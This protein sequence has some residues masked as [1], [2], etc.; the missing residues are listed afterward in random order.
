[1]PVHCFAVLVEETGAWIILKIDRCIYDTLRLFLQFHLIYSLDEIS[2][3][4]VTRFEVPIFS[5]LFAILLT[6][7]DYIID[8]CFRSRYLGISLNFNLDLNLFAVNYWHFIV[9]RRLFSKQ[10]MLIFK[11]ILIYH[12]LILHLHLHFIF[13]ILHF[14]FFHFLILLLLFLS[15]FIRHLFNNFLLIFFVLLLIDFLVSNVFLIFLR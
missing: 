14:L 15:H 1:M 8:D 13:F 11:T 3:N 2:V 9:L 4:V 7:H 6:L 12:F 10:L 5:L